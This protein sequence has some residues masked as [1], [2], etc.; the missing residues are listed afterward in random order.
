MQVNFTVETFEA[1]D[2]TPLRYALM[3]SENP[4]NEQHPI[5]FV[6]GLGGTVKSAISFL[7]RLVPHHG[8]V[9]SMDARGFGLNEHLAPKPFPGSYLQDFQQF[10]HHLQEQGQLLPQHTPILIGLSLG[11]VYATLHVIQNQHPFKGLILVAP[12]FCPHPKL[13]TLGYKLKNYTQVLLKGVK[14][15]TT[16]PYG[17]KDLTRNSDLY[18]DPNFTDPLVLPSFYLFLVERLCKKAYTQTHRIH[19]PTAVVVPEQDMVCD[20]QAMQLAYDRIP[21]PNKTLLRYTD[22]FHDVMQE[23]EA[24]QCQICQDLSRWIA[25]LDSKSRGIKAY[26]KISQ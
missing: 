25:S 3:R 14:A 6:P 10:I 12:A 17:I 22:L 18:E 8:P 20:P 16:L 9:Y 21:H 24:D 15:M 1:T 7:E 11:G 19:V 26:Q 4:P 2:K 23:P 5:V 13:F